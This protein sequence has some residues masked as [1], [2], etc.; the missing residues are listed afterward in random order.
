MAD[1]NEGFDKVQPNVTFSSNR[2]VPNHITAPR[3]PGKVTTLSL[4][5]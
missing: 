1:Q 3:N 2:M 5:S 4:K